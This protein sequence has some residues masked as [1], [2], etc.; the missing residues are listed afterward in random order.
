MKDYFL[1]LFAHEHWAM[2]KLMN[3]L[4][5]YPSVPERAMILL[6]HMHVA[7]DFWYKRLLR[8]DT[9]G[10]SWWPSLSI[11]E[12]RALNEKN[13]ER[14][15]AAIGDLTEPFE[16]H[17]LTLIRRNGK[18]ATF[19]VIDALTQLH[20]HSVHHRAQINVALRGAGLEPV[21]TDYAPFCMKYDP[22]NKK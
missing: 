9:D 8:Q 22:E 17:T 19:R 6:G 2:N 21:D 15:P 18:P 4:E 14:W 20:S 13:R 5:G 10:F 11:S 7:H 3:A 1:K 16:A 12:C